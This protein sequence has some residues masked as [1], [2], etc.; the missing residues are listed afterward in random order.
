MALQFL[1][2]VQIIYDSEDWSQLVSISTDRHNEKEG[3]NILNLKGLSFLAWSQ[4][5]H[6]SHLA[7]PLNFVRGHV[8]KGVLF[9]LGNE[10]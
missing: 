3:S 8:G 5:P 4:F 2:A 1:F 6:L 10:G 7:L 9:P